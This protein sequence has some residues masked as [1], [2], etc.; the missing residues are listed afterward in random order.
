MN[1]K[2]LKTNKGFTLIEIL[3]AV[4]VLS[5]I[6][7]L[8]IPNLRKFSQ[9]QELNDTSSNVLRLLERAHSSAAAKIKCSDKPATE[10]IVSFT[11]T[12]YSLKATC[13]DISTYPTPLASSE[14]FITANYSSRGVAVT[15][16][17]VCIS[18]Y[19]DLVFSGN[20]INFRC[21]DGSLLTD[22]SLSLT[23]SDNRS[24][25]PVTIVVDKGGAIYES[26]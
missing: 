21:S 12:S 26:K 5:I 13:Q 24:N 18:G 10:W 25:P 8:S 17:P 7:V 3:V 1:H 20:N 22:N 6:T 9:D 19:P 11:T 2:P 15:V 16:S 14:T 23:L 4:S